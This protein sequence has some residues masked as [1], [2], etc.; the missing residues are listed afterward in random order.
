MDSSSVGI[1]A[2]LAIGGIVILFIFITVIVLYVLGAY[3][4]YKM[5]TNDGVENAWLAW[6]PIA[7]MYILAKL[8]KTLSIGSYK[9]PNLDIVL[10]VGAIASS[11]LSTIPIIG[12]LIVI[13]YTIIGIFALHKLYSKYRPE[14]ATLFLIL[15]IIFGFMAPI[16]IFI[17]RN[18]KAV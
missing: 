2:L 6:I 10:T 11:V 18:D 4:L 15:S 5:A 8:I 13:A 7:N 16:F 17:M 9:V 3:G 14:N 1:G 12:F